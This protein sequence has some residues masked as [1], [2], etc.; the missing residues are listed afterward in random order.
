[1][2]LCDSSIRERNSENE[3]RPIRSQT[4]FRVEHSSNDSVVHSFVSGVLSTG[5]LKNH[6]S[7]NEE[8]IPVDLSV[9]TP[10]QY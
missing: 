3:N 8:E 7:S 9:I 2:Q 6:S 5:S 4:L 1:M 10:I